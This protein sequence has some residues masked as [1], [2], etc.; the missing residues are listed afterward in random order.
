MSGIMPKFEHDCDRC[1]FLATGTYRGKKCD[2]YIC[3]DSDTLGRTFIA[4]YGSVPS[5]Y[6]SGSLFI[7]AELTDLDKFALFYGLTLTDKEKVRL[8]KL[9]LHQVYESM[10]FMFHRD[11]LGGTNPDN[12]LG[13]ENHFD[14]FMCD[15]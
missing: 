3:N 6:S 7:C 14:R 5:Q 8:Y 1:T 11:V 12:M 4:R 2:F 13:P 15:E 9:L 10:S